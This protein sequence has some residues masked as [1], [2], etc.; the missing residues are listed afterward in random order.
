MERKKKEKNKKKQE[1]RTEG[2]KRKKE[3][4]TSQRCPQSSNS[5]HH[6]EIYPPPKLTNRKVGEGILFYLQGD[7]KIIYIGGELTPLYLKV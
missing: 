3:I 1:E 4:Y 2:E 7:D 5:N 6:L